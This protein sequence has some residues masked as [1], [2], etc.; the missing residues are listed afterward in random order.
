VIEATSAEQ[1]EELFGEHNGKIDL[2]LTDVVMP[3]MSGRELARRLSLRAPQMRVLFMSGY[4][5]NLIAQGGVLEA[6]VSFLQKPFSPRRLAAKVRDVLD[7][8][9]VAN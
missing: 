7:Q 3:G 2:L 1:A 6:G 8:P 5:D 9:L 4:T